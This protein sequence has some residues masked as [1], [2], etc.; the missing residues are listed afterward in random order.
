M[1]ASALPLLLLAAAGS[2]AAAALQLSASPAALSSSPATIKVSWSGASSESTDWVSIYCVGAAEPAFGPWDYVSVCQGWASGSCSLS[3]EVFQGSCQ[4]MEARMYRDPSPYTLLATSNTMHWQAPKSS[5][6]HLRLAYGSSAQSQMHMSWTSD[7]GSSPSW[8]ELGQQPGAYS[9]NVS[10]APALTYSAEDYCS[11]APPSIS[12]PGFFHH[13]LIPALT[14]GATYYARACQ[15]GSACSS[16]VRWQSGKPKGAQVATSFAAFAD[17]GISSGGAATA[18][19]LAALATSLD[20]AVHVGDL[21]YA[22]GS[23]DVW[24][25]WMGLIEPATRVLPYHVSIGNRKRPL[26]LLPCLAPAH[27]LTEPL[28]SPP[29]PPLRR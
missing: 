19:R 5:L 17:M 27:T 8:L 29:P 22:L 7:D 15:A 23:V 12:S 1:A 25:S 28:P 14:A 2:Q 4:D 3:F 11:N 24:E 13:A 10:A 20:F 21:S 16:E 9:L 6:R 18:A 26:R